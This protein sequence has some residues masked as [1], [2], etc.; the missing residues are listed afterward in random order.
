MEKGRHEREE[1]ELGGSDDEV[2]ILHLSVPF[3]AQLCVSLF[4]LVGL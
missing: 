1:G 3:L 2:S 4:S